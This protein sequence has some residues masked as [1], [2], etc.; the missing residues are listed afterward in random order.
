MSHI[1]LYAGVLLLVVAASACKSN[2]SAVKTKDVLPGKWAETPIYID[3]DSKDWPSPYPNYDS[4][5][6]IGYATANDGKNLY[7]T[8][9]TGD[10]LTQVKILKGGLT[11]AVDTSGKKDPTFTIRYPLPNDNADLDLSQAGGDKTSAMHTARQVNQFV[12]KATEQANQ[13]SLS[14]FPGCEGGYM[15][16]QVNTCGIKVKVRLDEYKELVWEAVI[17]LKVLY[18]KETITAADAGRPVSICFT[19]TGIKAPKSKGVDNVNGNGSPGMGAPGG[20]RNSMPSGGGGQR[21][22]TN[23][24]L[25]H[26]YNTTKTWKQTTL[27]WKQ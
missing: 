14:G 6:K 19:A 18:G 21:S 13:F 26:L 9:E 16:A 8:M 24:P 2:K 20:Q 22:P 23:N 12:H 4:K 27:S 7:I 10:E 25:D 3:G 5:A 15:T 1:K 11:V 17:P